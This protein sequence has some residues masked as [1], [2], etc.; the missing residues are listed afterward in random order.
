MTQ[1]E[2]VFFRLIFQSVSICVHLWFLCCVQIF[3]AGATVLHF[4]VFSVV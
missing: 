4:F 1:E 3:T 2:A